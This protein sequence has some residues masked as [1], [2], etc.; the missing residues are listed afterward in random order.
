MEDGK[1]KIAFSGGEEPPPDFRP[2]SSEDEKTF[3][4][5][6]SRLLLLQER[7]RRVDCEIELNEIR[8]SVAKK[9]R[10]GFL[11]AFAEVSAKLGK[12]ESSLGIKQASDFNEIDGRF[13]VRLNDADEKK[14]D[15]P[16]NA[17]ITHTS[18]ADGAK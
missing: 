5:L 6:S 16:I 3:R 14:E 18:P 7:L 2:M 13:F 4:E 17:T 12:L 9:E 15:K 8:L 1:E 10:I 11:G